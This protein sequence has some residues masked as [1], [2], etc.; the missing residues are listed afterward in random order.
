[1]TKLIATDLDGTLLNRESRISQKNLE[2]I[3]HAQ[4]LGIEV[5]VATGRAQFD[6]KKIFENTGMNPWIIGTNGATIHQPN[7]ELFHAVPL[8]EK[9]VIDITSWLEQEDFYYEVFSDESI[10]TPN[11]GRELLAIEID[12]VKSANPDINIGEL[13]NAAQK[14]FSQTGF[15]F[16]QSY[17]D[18][19]KADTDIYNILAFSFDEEKL[20]KGWGKFKSRN[21]LTLV[22]S[23]KHNFELEHLD[24]SK[25][26]ALKRLANKLNIHLDNTAAI[27][28]SYNDLSMLKI[29]GRSAAMENADQEIKNACHEVAF[30]NDEDGVAHFIYSLT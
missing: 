4:A 27:G 10:F 18:L 5:V 2:A 7:G 12:R 26:L 1:M 8:N 28:D 24:A 9:D 21:D 29:A 25:G 17:K 30:T 19:L 23:A 11:K 13:Q 3:K 16:I 22:K 15:S 20:E 14:Q 6:V